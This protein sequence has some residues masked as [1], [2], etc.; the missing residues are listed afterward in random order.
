MR[1]VD[2]SSDSA[3]Q[4]EDAKTAGVPDG[5]VGALAL[6]PKVKTDAGTAGRWEWTTALA[7]RWA[8]MGPRDKR[9]LQ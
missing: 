1:V 9:R 3:S 7:D 2:A 8:E 6:H 5:M 4:E